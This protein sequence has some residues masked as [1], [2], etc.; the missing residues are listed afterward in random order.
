MT[1]RMIGAAMLVLLLA[2]SVRADDKSDRQA[3]VGTWKI[4]VFQ[5]DGKD[6]RGRLGANNDRPAKLVFTADACFVLRGD[7]KRETKSGLSNCAWKSFQLDS[8]ALPPAIELTGFAGK[9]GSKTK[10]YLGIYQLDGDK[11]QICYCEQGKTRPTKFESDGAMNLMVCE[12][13]SREPLALPDT[14]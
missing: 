6:R 2:A 5:D 13:I 11:L 3:L 4:T 10:T 9:D 8:S 7:G 14:P 1:R 12:R